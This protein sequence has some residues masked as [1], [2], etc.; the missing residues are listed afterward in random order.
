MI[1]FRVLYQQVQWMFGYL[2]GFSD[3]CLHFGNMRD[4]VVGYIIDSIYAGDLD[5]RRS[6]IKY[7]FTIEG[8]AIN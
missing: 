4:G 6:F 2:R 8:C 7:A 3:I 1:A 5:K